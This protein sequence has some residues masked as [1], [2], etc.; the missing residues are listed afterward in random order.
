MATNYGIAKAKVELMSTAPGIDVNPV[1]YNYDMTAF[2][3][4]IIRNSPYA[5]PMFVDQ[6]KSS[7]GTFAALIPSNRQFFIDNVLNGTTVTT[8]TTTNSTSTPSPTVTW[9]LLDAP[10]E[11]LPKQLKISTSSSFLDYTLLQPNEY[12]TTNLQG[13]NGPVWSNETMQ[14]IPPPNDRA[15]TQSYWNALS[16]YGGNS[17]PDITPTTSSVL[18]S[19]TWLH[20]TRILDGLWWAIE[21]DSILA[22]NQPFFINLKKLEVPPSSN[23]GTCYVIRLGGGDTT[24][25]KNIY[26]IYISLN[27]KPILIDYLDTD[28]S[29]IT[30]AILDTSTQTDGVGGAGQS[31]VRT[32]WSDEVSKVMTNENEFIRVGVQTVAGRLVITINDIPLV[33]NRI[34]KSQDSTGSIAECKIKAGKI[35]VFGTNIKTMI[36]MSMMTY[37]EL[38][39]IALPIPHI[40]PPPSIDFNQA[41]QPHYKGTDNHGNTTD[42]LCM[43]P[44]NPNSNQKLFGCD[45]S[46]FKDL[47]AGSTVH[48]SGDA[49]HQQGILTYAPA[50]PNVFTSLPDYDFCILFF[51]STDRILT[52]QETQY[53]IPFSGAPYFF[54]LKGWSPTPASP[55]QSIPTDITNYLMSLDITESA[56]DYFHVTKKANLTFYNENNTIG[57]LVSNSQTAIRIYLGWGIATTRVFTGLVQT[58]NKTET[59]GYETLTLQCTDYMYILEHFPICNSPFYDGMVAYYAIEDLAKRAGITSFIKDWADEDDY[60]LPSGYSFTEPRMYFKPEDMIYNC[61]LNIIQRFEA[62]FFFDADGNLHIRKL[63]GGLFSVDAA[64]QSVATFT[65]DI[66]STNI[67][68]VILEERNLTIDFNSTVNQISI[69]SVERDTR[70]YI[71]HG[72]PATG[73]QN[74]ILFK[75]PLMIKQ[76][77]LGELD[78]V[79]S[80][81]QDLAK[82]VFYPILKTSFKAVNNPQQV[83]SLDFITLDG[84]MFRVTSIKREFSVEENNLIVSY[85]CEWLGGKEL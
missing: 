63:P 79:R 27:K 54:R 45:C 51:E 19:T 61:I 39:I 48:P 43:L 83:N 68:Y 37:A 42:S 20:Q 50:D 41:K 17:A 44:Q 85:D 6:V 34:N 16:N 66:N 2:H 84:A 76:G 62:F 1:R 55:S 22:D 75:K 28:P 80:Y 38:G 24:P 3:W 18:A 13:Y 69:T 15:D 82:R 8:T 59:A 56:D 40:T 25:P 10:M 12:T 70:S 26:D 11:G 64:E 21:S 71:F 5:K 58:V 53:T 52:I 32:E 29:K 33:Y 31:V 9:N 57:Q 36:N 78:V 35:Q 67:N 60:F 30:S 77:A 74:K 4:D 46:T 47:L 14:A 7:D 81:A 23:N 73:D 72:L 49:F 65:S